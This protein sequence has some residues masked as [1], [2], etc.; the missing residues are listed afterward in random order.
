MYMRSTVSSAIP[1]IFSDNV[2]IFSYYF[3]GRTIWGYTVRGFFLFGII[4]G[5]IFNGSQKSNPL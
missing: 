2:K 4:Q 5:G 3:D 1:T